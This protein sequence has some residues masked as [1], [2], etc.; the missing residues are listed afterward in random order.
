MHDHVVKVIYAK[1]KSGVRLALWSAQRGT[2]ACRHAASPL[3]A[4]GVWPSRGLPTGFGIK[5]K[6]WCGRP[7]ISGLPSDLVSCPRTSALAFSFPR[8]P[9]NTPPPPRPSLQEAPC[10]ASALSL[11]VTSTEGSSLTYRRLH[12]SQRPWVPSE[13]YYPCCGFTY[14][15]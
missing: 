6:V 3:G 9:S 8:L 7:R 4:A 2:E 10:H 1:L 11:Y 13:P 14:L 5:W 12:D 15:L